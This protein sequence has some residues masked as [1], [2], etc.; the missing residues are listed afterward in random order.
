MEKQTQPRQLQ[1]SVPLIVSGDKNR[2]NGNNP[3]PVAAVGGDSNGAPIVAGALLENDNN[4]AHVPE[5]ADLLAGN[6]FINKNYLTMG[7]VVAATAD[8]GGAVAD[9]VGAA[10]DGSADLHDQ[11]FYACD[12]GCLDPPV[13][14]G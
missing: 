10:A 3:A 4:K 9:V 1:P 7:V 6:A 8:V 2:S 13:E 11:S 5:P 12:A 14:L